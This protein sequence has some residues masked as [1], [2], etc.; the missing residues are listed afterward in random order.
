M[1]QLLTILVLSLGL[2]S[3]GCIHKASGPITP[4]ERVTTDNAVF[5]QLNNSIEQ[6]AEA[7]SVSGLL[8]PAQVAPVIAF[9][10]QA[11]T[12]HEQITAV[13]NKG[14]SVSAADYASVQAL[15][16]QIQSS[17]ATLVSSGALGIKNPKSQQTISADIQSLSNLASLIL[18]ELSA[19][20]P[21]G[22]Q[23]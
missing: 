11:A 21:K 6:G 14:T 2:I 7:V 4:V 19:Y 8:K 16:A 12:V 13:L 22:T 18:S 1:K 3:G 20:A 17:A 5:A 23:P 9:T 10:G 15:V